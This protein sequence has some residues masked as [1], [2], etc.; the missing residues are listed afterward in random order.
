MLR[1]CLHSIPRR[2]DLQIIVVDDK[3]CEAVFNELKKLEREFDY[4]T[5]IYSDTNGGGG[6]ARNIGIRHAVGK[7]VF[8]AD[9]DDFFNYCINDILDEYKNSSNDVV[10]FNANHIDTETYLPSMRKTT[11]QRALRMYRKDGNLNAFRYVFGE[12]WSK[13]IKRDIIEENHIRFDELPI[14]ND[15][16]FSYLVGFNANDIKFDN[17]ALYCLADRTGSVSKCITNEMLMIRTQV[18]AEKNKF[19]KDHDYSYFDNLMMTS[20]VIYAKHFDKKNFEKC[21]SIVV[22]YG[23]SRSFIYKKLIKLFLLRLPSKIFRLLSL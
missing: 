23:Y 2:A 16:K 20:F 5:F 1:R 6:K 14:H 8:F 18:F 13:L 17:R 3:S 15:T 7:Y 19:M 12:P 11:L 21:V 4:V 22:E 10:Y 9:A